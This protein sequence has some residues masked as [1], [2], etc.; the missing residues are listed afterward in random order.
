MEIVQIVGIGIIAAVLS[1]TVKK[2]SADIGLMISVAGSVLI[3]LIALPYIASI[4][5]MITKVG[6]HVDVNMSYIMHVIKVVGVA[7][8]AEFG[9]QICADAGEGSIASKIEMGGKVII[10][11]ISAP[12]LFSLIDMI[13]NIMP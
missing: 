5:D 11:L 1:V 6:E 8:I 7:Y 2:Q 4:V 3:F 13:L 10:M 9:A 12:I